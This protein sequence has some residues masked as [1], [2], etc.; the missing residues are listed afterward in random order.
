MLAEIEGMVLSKMH[1]KYAGIRIVERPFVP[2]SCGN[3]ISPSLLSGRKI[4]HI[5]TMSLLLIAVPDCI[6]NRGIALHIALDGV[7]RYALRRT[8]LCSPHH[9]IATIIRSEPEHT[10]IELYG[11]KLRRAALL[12]KCTW[13]YI[14]REY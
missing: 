6:S 2:H 13:N 4:Q 9:S 3:V 1:L 7:I 11:R 10:I 14:K 12:K 5:E 8:T